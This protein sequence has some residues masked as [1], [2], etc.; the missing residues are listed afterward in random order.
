MRLTLER[1]GFRFQAIVLGYIPDFANFKARV[2]VEVDGAPHFTASGMAG[3]KFK[4]EVLRSHG[5]KVVRVKNS[6]VR[7]HPEAVM[8][9]IQGAM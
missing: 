6:L 7:K 8:A 5:W 3:D 9:M 4:D 2:V 1:L